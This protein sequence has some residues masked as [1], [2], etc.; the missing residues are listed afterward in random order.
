MGQQITLL[1]GGAL[2]LVVVLFFGTRWSQQYEW[3]GDDGSSGA[4]SQQQE[5]APQGGEGADGGAPMAGGGAEGGAGGA[6]MAEG[7]AGGAQSPSSDSEPPTEL[8]TLVDESGERLDGSMADQ[9]D[10]LRAEVETAEGEEQRQLRAEMANLLIGAGAPGRAASVQ[11]EIADATE[12]VDDRRRAADL[13]YR[14]MQKLQGEGDREQA[15]EVARHVA[16][17]YGTVSDERPDDLDARTR[18]G[19]AYLLTNSPMRGIRVINAV[20]DE[21]S[22]FVP[23]R[24]QK[25]LAL[26]QINRL[27]QAL[28]EFASVQRHASEDDPFYKQAERAIEVIR[29]Q[30]SESSDGASG[31]SPQP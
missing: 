15:L 16:E 11:T 29:E 28:R 18:M 30:G 10:S 8:A 7:G 24:F 5:V 2:A 23:A 22:T 13:L 12:A 19:E 4:P 31:P 14:W 27:D 9:V 25:G 20:V 6:P 26:L 1:I 3:G 17:A 21:D